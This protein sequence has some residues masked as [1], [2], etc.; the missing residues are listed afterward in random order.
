MPGSKL[1]VATEP[2]WIIRAYHRKIGILPVS[3]DGHLARRSRQ[4]GS[5]SF[6]TAWKAISKTKMPEAINDLTMYRIRRRHHHRS[7]LRLQ[8]FE[9]RLRVD[10]QPDNRDDE[11]AHG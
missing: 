9:D 6:E 3:A 5:L 1:S 8:R 10:P 4:A 2:R 11:R 7:A